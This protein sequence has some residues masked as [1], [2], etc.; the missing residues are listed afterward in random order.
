MK[1]RRT[2][3]K[4]IQLTIM[5]F[6]QI[7]VTVS[8]GSFGGIDGLDPTIN[9]SGSSSTGD[10]DLEVRLH[11]PSLYEKRKISVVLDCINSEF[12]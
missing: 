6:N 3:Y 8:D 9:W 2:N 10:V 12:I 7:Q 11:D 5:F 1:V 4:I